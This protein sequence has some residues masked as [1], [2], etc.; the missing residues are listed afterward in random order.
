MI[1]TNVAVQYS[2]RRASSHADKNQ[3][4][5]HSDHCSIQM[6]ASLTDLTN[7]ASRARRI[8]WWNGIVGVSILAC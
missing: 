3:N 2:S 1:S 7:L 5:H 8:G 4:T 6:A